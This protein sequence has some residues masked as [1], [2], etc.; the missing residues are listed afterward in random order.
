MT[1]F[2]KYMCF[3]HVETCLNLL[4][5]NSC[6]FTENGWIISNGL[7]ANKT[8]HNLFQLLFL[9]HNM[10]LIWDVLEEVICLQNLKQWEVKVSGCFANVFETFR[11]MFEAYFNTIFHLKQWQD[12]LK[13]CFLVGPALGEDAW[14]PPSMDHPDVEPE[15]KEYVSFIPVSLLVP[16]SNMFWPV[17]NRFISPRS[18][19]RGHS[20]S[21]CERHWCCNSTV[22]LWSDI[23]RVKRCKTQNSW[24][25]NGRESSQTTKGNCDCLNLFWH[26]SNTLKHVL[27]E[28]CIDN[29]LRVWFLGL[30]GGSNGRY[31]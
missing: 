15:R 22:S 14:E 23:W 19:F 1:R 26:A 10:G 2:L 30:K 12:W 17:S 24:R 8:Q 20:L 29:W 28:E 3:K 21:F 16:V 13:H 31:L 18:I 6:L 5:T 25:S 7:N 9:M 27:F 4:V 11:N